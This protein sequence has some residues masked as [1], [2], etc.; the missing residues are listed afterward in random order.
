MKLL[1]RNQIEQMQIERNVC[2][3]DGMAVVQ[4]KEKRAAMLTCLDCANV[5]VLP[6]ALGPYI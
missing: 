4:S 1:S 5:I 3:I 2:I 6:G